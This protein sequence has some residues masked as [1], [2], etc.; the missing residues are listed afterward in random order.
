MGSVEYRPSQS[1]GAPLRMLCDLIQ[2]LRFHKSGIIDLNGAAEPFGGRLRRTAVQIAN[3]V[4]A[5]G[6]AWEQV[7]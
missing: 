7:I 4:I 3:I 6:A 1:S 5:I 2:M